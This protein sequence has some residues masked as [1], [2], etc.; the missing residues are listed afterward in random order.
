[1]KKT[2]VF[3]AL[4][5][6]ASLAFVSCQQEMIN[7]EPEDVNAPKELHFIVKAQHDTPTRTTLT[8]NGDGSYT[9]LWS[10]NDQLGAFLG[11][12]EISG[13]TNAVD[14]TLTNTNGDNAQG[15]FEGSAIA[16]GDGTF[17]AFYPAGA[18]AKGYSGGSIGLNIGGAGVGI[19]SGKPSDYIQH[20]T[21]TSPDPA[22]NILV[23]KPC[24]Y[25]SD[26]DVVVIDDLVFTR[27]LSILKVNL[28]G[29]VVDGELISWFKMEVSEG[30]LSGRVKMDLETPEILGWTSEMPYAW[31]EYTDPVDRPYCNDD[32]QVSAVY[33]VVNPTTI[34]AGTTV[35]FTAETESFEIE[36][37]IE[38]PSDLP[39]PASGMA[40]INLNIQ[41]SNCTPKGIDYYDLVTV[42][43]AFEDGAKYIFAFQANDGT[44]QFVKNNGGSNNLSDPNALSVDD[45]GVIENP[46]DTYVFTAEAGSVAGT[47]IFKNVNENYIYTAGTNTTLN[48]NGDDPCDWLPSFLVI[49]STYKL[50]FSDDSGRYMG[51]NGSTAVKAYAI[52][53]FFDQLADPEKDIAQYAG[54]I[55]V[56]KYRDAREPLDAPDPGTFYVDEMTLSWDAV[57]N[58]ASY[59]VVIDEDVYTTDTNSFLYS[60]EPGFFPVTVIAVPSDPANYKNSDPAPAPEGVMKFG[61][62]AI[63]IPALTLG[64]VTSTSITVCWQDD[65]NAAAGYH[66]EIWNTDGVV[67]EIDV[68][69]GVQEVTFDEYL[70]PNTEYTIYVNGNAVYDGLYDYDASEQASIV[71]S[72]LAEEQHAAD[73]VA[74]GNYVIEGL[75]VKAVANPSS[76]IAGDETGLVYVYKSNHNK[77]VGNIVSVSGSV[78]IYGASGTYGGILEFSNPTVTK[79]ADGDGTATH[80]AS[81][82]A[83]S[84]DIVE[85]FATSGNPNAPLFIAATGFQEGR[86]ITVGS[87]K[88]F[89]SKVND[90]TDGCIVNVEGYIYNYDTGHSSYNFAATSIVA[91]GEP[92]TLTVDATSKTWQY[93]ETTPF[94]VNVTSTNGGW[95]VDPTSLEWASINC[96]STT[97]TIT[98]NGNNTSGDDYES[99]ITVTHE[100]GYISKTIS[101]KQEKQPAGGEDVEVLNEEFDNNSTSD[102]S[103][104]FN[105]ST[106]SNF[107]GETSKAYKSKY[108]G[109]KLGT[110][111]AVGYIT[112]K[113]LNLSSSF[114]VK[115]NVLK[116]GTDTGTVQVTVGSVT[117]EITPTDTDTQYS[118]DFNA[119]TTSS[120]VM[121]GTS[122][123]RAYIDNVIIIRHD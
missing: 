50:Q 20:P 73:V 2:F 72:T 57:D 59:I 4:V 65:P 110:G 35:T 77:V 102:S 98:P 8:N 14:F 81:P 37:V 36:K 45:L 111:S 87:K 38:L 74:E 69:W 107:S 75:E 104:A 26:G 92:L 53:N 78:E 31:A 90:E 60:G 88:L 1:M 3:S 22:C 93:N 95:T 44:Y 84:D 51:H 112:S 97:L 99:V 11:T 119:A 63:E 47:F 121:I 89:L 27:P 83:M 123:K 115:I 30:T 108:G 58:A 79:T 49:S 46:A 21:G 17:R 116:Y 54:A 96:T 18:F 66:C 101:V 48:T 82:Y 61:S 23:S 62:P 122:A 34:A 64:E 109:V 7:P 5:A 68:P 15:V 41:S 80:P 28:K 55:S 33:L 71:V 32:T 86:Y 25:V 56:F 114:T 106:F 76:F 118:L 103:S 105:S 12:T 117:K 91:D 100:S 24:E 16:E 94:V 67:N 40:V 85:D 70:T 120:T 39:F 43:G 52:N 42:P 113:A 9:P 13:T 29:D 19:G 6:I 10:E